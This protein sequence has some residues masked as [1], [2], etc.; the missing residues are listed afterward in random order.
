MRYR[1]TANTT[2]CNGN[3]SYTYYVMLAQLHLRQID[4]MSRQD[5]LA[6]IAS[7][8]NFLPNNRKISSIISRHNKVKAFIVIAYNLL[9]N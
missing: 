2:K 6:G 7:I 1:S 3:I 9:V 5:T 4:Y 8:L